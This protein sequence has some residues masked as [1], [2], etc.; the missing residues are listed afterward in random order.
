MAQKGQKG[1]ASSAK[2]KRV[3]AA[4][5]KAGIKK[6]KARRVAKAVTTSS[7]PASK[8]ATRKAKKSSRRYENRPKAELMQRAKAAGVKGRSRM[9]RKQL[10]RALRAS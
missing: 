4:L 6:K 5:R 3:Y 9:S 7:R 8:R 10:I 2:H 1:Q